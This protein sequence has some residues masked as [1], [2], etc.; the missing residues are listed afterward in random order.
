MPPTL[1]TA[2]NGSCVLPERPC[3]PVTMLL[4]NLLAWRMRHVV[5]DSTI[6]SELG[7]VDSADY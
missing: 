2:I 6:T 3:R 7:D 1:W 5:T 4:G